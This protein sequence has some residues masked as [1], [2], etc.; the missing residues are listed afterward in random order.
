MPVQRVKVK[1]DRPDPEMVRTAV[2]AIRAGELVVLPTES[3]YG[4][5]ADP[6]IAAAVDR[7]RASKGR[8]ASHEFTSH[9]ASREQA[10]AT[11]PPPRAS[12]RRLVARYWP[13]PLTV[14]VTGHAGNTV[15]LRVPAH[16]F[17]QQV[18]AEFPQG[19][20]LTSVN[21]SGMPPLLTPD[22]IAAGFP[23]IDLLCDAGPPAL[24]QASAVVRCVDRE[25]QVLREGTLLADELLA[26]AA[27]TVLF[28]CSGNTCRSPMAAAIARHKVAAG[29]GIAEARVVARGLRIASAGTAAVPGI[30]PADAALLAMAEIGLDIG[31]HRSQRIDSLAFGEVAR[32][33]AMTESHVAAISNWL[34]ELRGRLFLLDPQGRDIPDPFGG[35]LPVYREARDLIASAIEQRLPELVGLV[36]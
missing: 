30:P 14:V 35:E 4:A 1:A 6:T 5:A 3:V 31:A 8:A 33:Y 34:P 21:R 23:E 2:D 15:G 19:L 13:G 28:V 18:L 36:S 32:V 29:L 24:G 26:T 9:F 25:V 7:L 27:C 16:A 20:Y 11:V 22:E 10:L 17:T 12:A